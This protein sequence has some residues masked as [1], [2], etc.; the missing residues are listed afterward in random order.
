MRET[1]CIIMG[2]AGRDFH[3]FLTWFRARPDLRVVA[4]TAEQI[5]FIDRRTFPAELAGP[6]YPDGIPIVPESELEALVSRHK[7]E[8][9]FLAYSDLAYADVM[10]K[11]ARVQAAGASFAMLG[12][13]QTML[14][15]ALPVIA[16]TAARTGCGKSP[17]CLAIARHLGASGLRVG[18]LRHPMPYGDL[19]AQAVQRFATVDDLERHACTVE[20]RE[21]YMPYVERGMTIFA[22]V[23]YARILELAEMESDVILWDGGNNDTPFVRPA[24]WICVIDALRP[25]HEVA[26]YPGET[27]L[28]SAHVVVIN[29]VD[30]ADPIALAAMRERV[31][32]LVPKAAVVES[33]LAFELPAD[34]PPMRGRRVL[35]V[36]DGPTLTHGGMPWGAAYLAAEAAHAE[37]VDPRPF[38]VG[39]VAEAYRRYPHMGRA[40][41]ALGYSAEQRAELAATIHAAAPDLVIDA[42]PARI[43]RVLGLERPVVEVGYRFVQRSGPDL[44]ARAESVARGASSS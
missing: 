12:P 1:R 17:L 40:L 6:R 41:P 11:V 32:A 29:K 3:D 16:V 37:L 34:A 24:L 33:D 18:V 15:S 10:H 36:D 14:P 25:G 8:L 5:P 39:S 9:V 4:F 22:G 27:N 30:R 42:S 21:E 23:D 44:L 7:V 28:R 19:A 43:G 20:E 35:A 31:R 26:Y 13:G 38:A 2:A